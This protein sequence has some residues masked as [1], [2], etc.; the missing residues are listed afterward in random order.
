MDVVLQ[1][2]DHR[3]HACTS[4][5]RFLLDVLVGCNQLILNLRFSSVSGIRLFPSS[6]L[7]NFS[8][9]LVPQR[10]NYG[11]SYADNT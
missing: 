4:A 6:L 8:S 9:V 3:R 5:A 11:A 1:Y 2:V 10:G 7:L